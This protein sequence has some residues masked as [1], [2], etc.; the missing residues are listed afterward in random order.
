MCG[1]K[2]CNIRFLGSAA[3]SAGASICP[4]PSVPP[5]TEFESI[6]EEV[7]APLGETDREPEGVDVD[8]KRDETEAFE[9]RYGREDIEEAIDW[10]SL[11]LGSLNA[12]GALVGGAGGSNGE[13]LLGGV[14]KDVE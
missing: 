4:S 12:G 3:V 10:L 9:A 6:L 7:A 13:A 11:V 5:K 8:A 2:A 14:M 1:T